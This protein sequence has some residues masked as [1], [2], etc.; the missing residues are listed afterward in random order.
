MKE[1]LAHPYFLAG[2]SPGLGMRKGQDQDML[3]AAGVDV[4]P[5]RRYGER[6]GAAGGKKNKKGVKAVWMN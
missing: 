6:G 1:R 3:F 2:N 4:L 5:Q